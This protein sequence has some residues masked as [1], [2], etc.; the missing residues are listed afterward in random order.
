MMMVTTHEEDK[1]VV[2]IV[3][4]YCSIFIVFTF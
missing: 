3:Y 2:D 4:K 1:V